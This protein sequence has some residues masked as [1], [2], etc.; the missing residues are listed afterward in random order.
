MTLKNLKCICEKNQ[1]EKIGTTLLKIK[2]NYM[3]ICYTQGA[4]F[5]VNCNAGQYVY[6]NSNISAY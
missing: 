1:Y 6:L 2:K 3:G 5:K 4:M